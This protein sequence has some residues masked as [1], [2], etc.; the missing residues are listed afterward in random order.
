MDDLWPDD[1][2]ETEE[3]APIVLLKQQAAL[4]G[5]KTRNK[6]VGDIRKLEGTEETWALPGGEFH[7]AFHL[8]GPALGR[9]SYR[10]FTISH[11]IDLYPLNISLDS[12]VAEEKF[13]EVLDRILTIKS[14]PEFLDALKKI[15]AASKTR[16]VIGAIIS[17]SK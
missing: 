7:F 5:Q 17:Q 2:K 10:L 15:F 8:V 11:D 4:L 13:P 14:E 1:L 9:Y 12:N 3:E 6:V 16:R